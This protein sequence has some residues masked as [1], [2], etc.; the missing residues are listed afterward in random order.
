MIL[1]FTLLSVISAQ[2]CRD[3][4][5]YHKDYCYMYNEVRH[6]FALAESECQMQGGHL[7]SLLDREEMEVVYQMEEL[8]DSASLVWL[9]QYRD[10]D[11][12]FQ[13]TDGN[14]W[15]E[16]PGIGDRGSMPWDKEEPSEDKG[17]CTRMNFRGVGARNGLW[18]MGDCD[19]PGPFVCKYR[20]SDEPVECQNGFSQHGDQCYKHYDGTKMNWN[21][22]QRFCEADNGAHLVE[23]R[24][25]TESDDLREFLDAWTDNNYDD[26][27][28][29]L[30]DSEDNPTVF[31][32]QSS[33]ETVRYD[34]WYETEPS[35]P[36]PGHNCVKI[37][38]FI[39]FFTFPNT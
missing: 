28:I 26:L 20:S 38:S 10:K 32:W 2:N 9:G 25:E 7:M 1:L 16:W 35:N 29:G 12:K 33:G 27:W 19:L 30:K 23:I 6:P 5:F 24:S 17:E 21:D 3:G 8:I 14:D 4:W 13:W 15:K 39:F 31:V 34:N 36:K 22:A 37:G 11:R 18:S